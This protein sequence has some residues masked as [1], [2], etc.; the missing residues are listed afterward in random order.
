MN[1]QPVPYRSKL[2]EPFEPGQTLI[3]KGKT[4]ED[5]VRY[6]SVLFIFHLFHIYILT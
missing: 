5:S 1:F 4:A 2:T 6:V 3:I